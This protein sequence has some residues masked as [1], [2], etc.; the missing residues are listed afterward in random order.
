MSFSI[1]TKNGEKPFED[2]EIIN[3]SSKEV[4]DVQLDLGFDYMLSVENDED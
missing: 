4:F 1:I 3:I 2:K